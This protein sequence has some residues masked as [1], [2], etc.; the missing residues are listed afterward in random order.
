MPPTTSTP[1]SR[2]RSR[3]SRRLGVAQETVLGKGDELEVEEG[4]DLPL[5][6]QQR[7]DRQ[8]LIVADIDMAAHR[9]AAARDGPAAELERAR[10]DRLDG[11]MR[12]QLRPELDAFQQRAALV[13]PRPAEAE[14][15]IHM[16]MRIDEGRGDQPAAD[17]DLAGGLGLDPGRHLGDA[18]IGDRDIL[19]FAAVREIGASKDEIEHQRILLKLA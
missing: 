19:A 5:H 12:L 9:E 8:K 10:L 14:G 13:E 3:F 1:L 6:L 15:R 4:G 16:E 18:P 17:V 2:A 11:Q 7:L